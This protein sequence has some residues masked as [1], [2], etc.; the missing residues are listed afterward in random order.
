MSGEHIW[1]ELSYAQSRAT[2]ETLHLWT[3]IVGKIRLA[4][5]PW[6]IHSWHSTLYLTARGLTTSPIPC[7]ERTFE[8]YFDFIDHRLLIE[9]DDGARQ[10]LALREQSVADFHDALFEALRALGLKVRIH[11]VPNEVPDPIP[12]FEHQVH[13]SYDPDYV[14]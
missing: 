7:G 6:N 12:F 3:Q 14:Y 11:G 5:T 8:I 13:R 9:V 1:P 10:A 2:C 4:L